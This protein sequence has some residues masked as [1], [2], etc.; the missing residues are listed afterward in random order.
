M[1]DFMKKPLV[2]IGGPTASGKT[3]IA[4][5]LCKAMGGEVISAD[6]MQV[7][8]TMDIGTAKVT[9]EEKDG[10]KHYGVDIIEPT[11]EYNVTSFKDMT[12]AAMEEIYA[13]GKIPVITGGTGFYIQAVLYD[14]SFNENAE[15]SEEIRKELSEYAKNQGNHALYE[16]LMKVDPASCN[17]I[18]ENNV[19]RVIRAL[20]YYKTTGK[21]ISEHNEEERVK[22]SPYNYAYFALDMPREILY[23][24]INKRVDIMMENGLLDEARTVYK[25]GDSLSKTAREAIGYA[26]L[27]DYFD[28]KIT[29]DEAKEAIKQNS[30]RYAKRQLTW[31]R[32]EKDVIW[33]DKT[34]YG[35]TSDIINDMLE[36]L[37]NKGI[38]IK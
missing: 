24:R 19:K 27:F 5:K 28:E 26:E 15:G 31:L 4:V 2:I 38:M 25:L 22:E 36:T 17:T 11:E 35:S 3:D 7:Y 23:E 10:I 30:R 8:K 6:S 34:K 20:E 13:K 9:E 21:K 14:I 32:R 1:T 12:L 16:E 29:L 33:I 18:H 37:K